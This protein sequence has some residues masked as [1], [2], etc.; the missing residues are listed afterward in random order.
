[1]ENVADI[2]LSG[3]GWVAV[4]GMSGPLHAKH[5][6]EMAWAAEVHD[7]CRA[8]EIPFLFKQSSDIYTERGING[9]SLYLARRAG[10]EV[11]PATVPLIRE[12]PETAL[13]LLPF[14]EHGQRFSRADFRLYEERFKAKAFAAT[15][16]AQLPSGVLA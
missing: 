10:Q 12:Y 16:D 1:M 15:A 6:M 13:P 14:V 7:L 11:D 9:L 3:I 4:G 8:L 5:K 2:D